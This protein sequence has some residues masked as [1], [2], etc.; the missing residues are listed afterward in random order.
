[1]RKATYNGYTYYITEDG[2]HFYNSKGKERPIQT[3]KK[4]QNRKY[5]KLNQNNYYISVLVAY[6]FPEI[7]G[8]WFEGCVVHHIDGDKTNNNATNLMVLSKEE[9]RKLHDGIIKQ[10]DM[11]DNLVGE[12]Q[13]SFEAAKAIGDISKAAAIRMCLSSNSKTSCGYI[14]K[15]EH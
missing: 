10:Y 9:H 7:C 3:N 12:Y 4:R 13:N 11:D 5:I 1:M 6:A 14:W 8:E 2:G 15:R